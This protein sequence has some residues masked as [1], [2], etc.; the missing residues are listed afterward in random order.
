MKKPKIVDVYKTMHKSSGLSDVSLES[1]YS[2]FVS[3]C[4]EPQDPLVVMR[5]CEELK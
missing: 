1:L 4:S 3:S 5:D 2:L